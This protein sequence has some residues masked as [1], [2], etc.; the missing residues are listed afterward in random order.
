MYELADV[1]SRRKFDR[2][3]SFLDRKSFVPRWAEI[4]EFVSIIQ[5]V[6]ECRDLKDD[7]FL[8]VAWN[9][10]AD[11]ILTGDA[12]LLATHSWRDVALCRPRTISSAESGGSGGLESVAKP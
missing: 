4:T 11:V 12:D 6:R 5:L 3:V 8:E 7:K 1:L 2:Y 10:R 9:G